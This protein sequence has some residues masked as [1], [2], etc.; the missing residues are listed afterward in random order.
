MNWRNVARFWLFLGAV[1]ALAGALMLPGFA[2][3]LLLSGTWEV[4]TITV[5]G[6]IVWAAIVS[7]AVGMWS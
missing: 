6:G 4:V 7:V 3:A 2:L 1:A 5:Y